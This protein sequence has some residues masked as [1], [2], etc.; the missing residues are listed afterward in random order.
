MADAVRRNSGW[1]DA[2][3][4]D[5]GATLLA[6]DA[7]G[8]LILTDDF[9]RFLLARPE[10][11]P[12]PESCSAERAVHDRLLATPRCTVAPGD[13]AAIQDRDAAGNYAVWLRWRVVAGSRRRGRPTGSM[14][15]TGISHAHPHTPKGSLASGRT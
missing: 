3:W 15:G 1:P 13:L 9:L 2:A 12:I 10:L 7:Q 8:R 6:T 14:R 11:A 4:R 5:C